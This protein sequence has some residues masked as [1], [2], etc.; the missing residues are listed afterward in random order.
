MRS[1]PRDD[2]ATPP[3]PHTAD[4]DH[5]RHFAEDEPAHEDRDRWNE[6]GGPGET[7]GLTAGER[8]GP[9]RE[10][11]RR[12]EDGEE[13]EAADG[14]GWK[15]PKLTHQQRRQVEASDHAD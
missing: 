15:G 10:R 4:G 5:T 11:D 14:A 2:P 13:D 12:R 9:R 6:V 1:L 3:Q 8:I 7:S